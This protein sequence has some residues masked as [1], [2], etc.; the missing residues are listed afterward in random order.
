MAKDRLADALAL[1]QAAA[2]Q[3]SG[4]QQVADLLRTVEQEL[5]KRTRAKELED[6]TR[7]ARTFLSQGKFEEVVSLIESCF[8]QERSLQELK[9]RAQKEV[10]ARR[11]EALVQ[12]A[13]ATGRE[14]RYEDAIRIVEQAV[15]QY[16][17]TETTEKLHHSLRS[18]LEQHLKR[19]ARD[20]DQA[21][22]LSL[23][24]QVGT[25]PRKGKLG[26]ISAEVQAIA[27]RYDSDTEIAQIAG[28]IL[29]AA[30]AQA[31]QT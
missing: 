23:E 7:Q 10:D 31:A 21:Q 6:V 17:P 25:R 5:Q 20:R 29:E 3:Y 1:L 22:L 30:S 12:Q 13:I 24:Q 19:Q 28:R 27:A 4:E 11:R 16:G 8:P 14:K 26:K 2:A 18:S 9:D 15:S